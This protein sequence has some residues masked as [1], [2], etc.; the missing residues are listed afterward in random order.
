[1]QVIH[2]SVPLED[3]TQDDIN[4]LLLRNGSKLF[5]EADTLNKSTLKKYI[6]YNNHRYKMPIYKGWN[7]GKRIECT[8]H[9]SPEKFIHSCKKAFGANKISLDVN[10]A[11]IRI[12]VYTGKWPLVN[13]GTTPLKVEYKKVLLKDLTQDDIKALCGSENNFIYINAKGPDTYTQLRSISFRGK[14]INSIRFG[15][16][17]KPKNFRT[18]F[19]KA[20]KSSLK[21]ALSM[22]AKIKF[23]GQTSLLN[24]LNENTIKTLCSVNKPIYLLKA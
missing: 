3:L 8:P 14:K 20:V 7:T 5:M 4:Q 12:P 24:D 15:P 16:E 21:K 23:N 1:M 2:T 9:T 17:T 13:L 18:N 6:R 10:K 19:T 11:S 22:H